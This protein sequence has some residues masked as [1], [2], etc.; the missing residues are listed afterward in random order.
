MSNRIERVL[1][2]MQQAHLEQ[3][4][5]SDINSIKYL[6]GIRIYPGER[7]YVLLLRQDGQHTF[8]FNRLFGEQKTDF[9]V[10]W[11]NDGEDVISEIVKRLD[12]AK[13]VGIDK[14]WPAKFLIPLLESNSQIRVKLASDCIDDVRAVKDEEE[15]ELMRIASKINDEVI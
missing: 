12:A 13:P 14:E 11:Y 10:V 9:N 15:I 7:L 6:T 4:I 8:F 5:V 1:S 2:R 3:M